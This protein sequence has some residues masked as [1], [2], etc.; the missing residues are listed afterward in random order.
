MQLV[1]DFVVEGQVDDEMRT[2]GIPCSEFSR[3]IIADIYMNLIRKNECKS[4][5]DVILTIFKDIV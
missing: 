1:F 2:L 3:E 5:R 4:V